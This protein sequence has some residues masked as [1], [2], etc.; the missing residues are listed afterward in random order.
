MN[1]M[2]ETVVENLLER[3]L[4]VTMIQIGKPPSESFHLK[5]ATKKRGGKSRGQIADTC[6]R[7]CPEEVWSSFPDEPLEKVDAALE[8]QVVL[9]L[10]SLEYRVWMRSEDITVQWGPITAIQ[11]VKDFLDRASWH[12]GLILFIPAF[13]LL[14]FI[15]DTARQNLDIEGA[16]RYKTIVDEVVAFVVCLLYPILI[17]WWSIVK[18]DRWHEGC[19]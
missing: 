19:F 16:A 4:P 11:R 6:V 12:S 1:E 3:F 13:A 8:R 10:R 5:R 18:L 14:K 17:A 15:G 9:L 7:C 2:A